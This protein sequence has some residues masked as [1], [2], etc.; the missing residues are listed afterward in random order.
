MLFN[1]FSD[2]ISKTLAQYEELRDADAYLSAMEKIADDLRNGRTACDYPAKIEN[3]SAAKAF[4]GAVVN[5]FKMEEGKT[6]TLEQEEIIGECAIKIKEKIK[7]HTKRDWKTNTIVHKN[8]HRELDDCLFDLF[9][10]I[11][12]DC[13]DEKNIDILDN[14]LE[15]IIKIALARY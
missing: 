3:D 11:E 8:I 9:D 5:C 2:R 13:N 4:Y 7:Q 1:E 15:E 14:I 10:E 12:I 6:F